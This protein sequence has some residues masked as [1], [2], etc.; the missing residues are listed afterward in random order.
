MP[1]ELGPIFRFETRRLV[2]QR[3]WY[4]VRILLLLVLGGLFASAQ[5]A[6]SSVIGSRHSERVALSLVSDFH[7]GLFAAL[8]LVLAF[9]IAPLAAVATFSG[10]RGKYM[11]SLLLVTRLSGREV[12]WQSFA[13]GLVP[14]VT[15]WLCMLPFASFLAS[16][17]G[18]DPLYI[19]IVAVVTLSAMMAS[20]ASAVAFSLW[21]GRLFPTI[22]GVYSLWLCWLL[23]T[24]KQISP[25][26][27]PAWASVANPVV[28]LLPVS[29]RIGTTAPV[30]AAGFAAGALVFTIV[31][32]EIAAATFRRSVLAR[33]QSRSGK[34]TRKLSALWQ[35]FSRRPAAIGAP[36]LDWN[37]ILWR[38]W[39]HARG[40]LG[41]QTFWFLYVIGATVTNVSSAGAYS[42]GA[43]AHPVLAAAAGYELGIGV[44]A[45]AIQASLGWSEEKSAG[46]A[47]AVLL[48]STPLS[49]A[50]I[51]NG[52][53]LS[54]FRFIAP[55]AA[56]PVISSLIVLGNSLSS[57]DLKT[58]TLS[59]FRAIPVVVFVL[60][61]CLLYGAAFVSLGVLLATRCAKPS[62]AVFW[63]VGIYF[64]VAMFMPTL[65]E[66]FFL[67]NNRTLA[68]G[69]G[70]ASPIAAPIVVIMTRF[71][72][73]YFG[74][75]E[76]VFPFAAMWLVVVAAA[77]WGCYQW[78]IQQ[79]DRWMG[80]IPAGGRRSELVVDRAPDSPGSRRSARA[81]G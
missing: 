67:H 2:G 21:S 31:L 15:M 65:A 52:K 27:F 30:D 58:P 3:A 47:G 10:N 11:L 4:L 34:L 20:V 24:F 42:V 78:T 32:L 45:L 72:G 53:W 61:Q 22:L 7:S 74:P 33:E 17:W 62:H 43:G 6:Y 70:M 1:L 77:A 44:L 13:A 64:A 76:V 19:A 55:V 49:A 25:G 39:R 23:G 71:P 5:A 28:L 9:G 54:V 60:A 48:L 63:A 73:T 46:R 69:L 35:A 12:V 40:A 14:G 38:D 81:H 51:T 56:F 75:P 41:V 36:A 26:V 66:E 37:P 68:E 79:F 8:S 29:S 18:I 59:L 16:W 50:T 57:A 80:R